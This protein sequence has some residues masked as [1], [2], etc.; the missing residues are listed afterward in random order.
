Y[1]MAVM[2]DAAFKAYAYACRIC[3]PDGTF[4]V[5]HSKLAQKIGRRGRVSSQRAMLL[6]RQAG[7]V[8][9]LREGNSGRTNRAND[10]QLIPVEDI[11]RARAILA[12]GLPWQKRTADSN[13]N[14][15][16]EAGGYAGAACGG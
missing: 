16:P 4:F 6:L 14:P 3:R 12:A 11:E 2:P 15:T 7:L 13:S 8:R 10:Y 1:L 9:R 5:S